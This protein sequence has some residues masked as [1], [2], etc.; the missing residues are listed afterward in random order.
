MARQV[1][2]TAAIAAAMIVAACVP[3]GGERAPASLEANRVRSTDEF[4]SRAGTAID[5]ATHPGN[6]L[7]AESCATCH[8]GQVPKAPAIV[9]LE[10]MAPDAILAAMDGGIMSQQAAHLSTDEKTQIAEYL[11]RTSL[12]DYQAPPAPARC[13]GAAAAFSGAPPAAVG[14]GHDTAR[15]ISAEVGGITRDNV[16][17]LKLKWAFAY[18]S[19]VRARSQPSI[20]WNTIF[21]G[22]QDGTVYAFDLQSGCVKWTFRASAEVRTA[23]VADAAAKRLY[24]GDVLGRA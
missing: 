21:V 13:A 9:W 5:P 16:E 18:P 3:G 11:T 19:A 24:F 12:S 22:S 7:F 23:I 2:R 14:W 6:K 1:K 10:M 20:G 4:V 17:D 8:S 15:F